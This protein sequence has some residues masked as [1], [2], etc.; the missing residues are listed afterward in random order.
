MGK[1]KDYLETVGLPTRAEV[2]QVERVVKSMDNDL[3][4]KY[5]ED[6]NN[7]QL[8]RQEECYAFYSL[9]EDP[10][11]KVIYQALH[12]ITFNITPSSAR[13]HR[14]LSYYGLSHDV[15]NRKFR[16]IIKEMEE[17]MK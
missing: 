9:P 13:M 8:K 10:E 1:I 17:T 11:L 3:A 5:A 2:I 15:D 4:S 12:E 16:S 14:M 7:I 6:F